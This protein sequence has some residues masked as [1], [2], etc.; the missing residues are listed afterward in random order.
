MVAQE[1]ANGFFGVND[2]VKYGEDNRGRLGGG[3]GYV[4]VKVS[5]R[6]GQV[7]GGYGEGGVGLGIGAEV[8]VDLVA[9]AKLFHLDFVLI[10]EDIAVCRI[11]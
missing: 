10:D 2:R 1:V 11:M 4:F 7:E 3:K 9:F 6:E 8:P 5:D